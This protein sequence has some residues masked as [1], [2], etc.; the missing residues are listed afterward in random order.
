MSLMKMTS[1]YN[2]ATTFVRPLLGYP[3]AIYTNNYKNCF[4]EKNGEDYKIHLVF[5]KVDT[6]S[7]NQQETFKLLD[8]HI[9]FESKEELANNIIYTFRTD[10]NIKYDIDKFLEGKYSKMSD[11]GKQMIIFC[12]YDLQNVVALSAILWP[13]DEDR[14]EL[15]ERLGATMKDDAEV[16]S[17]PNLSDELFDKMKL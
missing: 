8:E 10:D 16:F 15:S 5:N 17:A 2:K 7:A 3:N 6:L 4:I 9:L 11:S 13:N 14:K 12:Q 1:S